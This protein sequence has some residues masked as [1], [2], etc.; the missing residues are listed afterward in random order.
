MWG[1]FH[2]YMDIILHPFK[3]FLLSLKFQW[4]KKN[5]GKK[6]SE[7]MRNQL[8]DI[9]E[10]KR[11]DILFSLYQKT[12]NSKNGLDWFLIIII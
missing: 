5:D 1:V 10:H 8:G 3:K 2:L 6:K 11:S 7:G 9:R 12:G 4:F